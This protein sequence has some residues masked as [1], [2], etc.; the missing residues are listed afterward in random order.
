MINTK[1]LFM[2]ISIRRGNTQRSVRNIKIEN[3]SFS[4]LPYNTNAIKIN[5]TTC[6]YSYLDLK[7]HKY[8]L[9]H[10]KCSKERGTWHTYIS[11]TTQKEMFFDVKNVSKIKNMFYS[12]TIL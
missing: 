3:N 8:F 2:T 5:A 1:C 4:F 11:P 7:M 12:D 9:Q 10:T 6:A